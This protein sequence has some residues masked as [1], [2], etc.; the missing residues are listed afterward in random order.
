MGQAFRRA[1]GRIGSSGVDT[2]PSASSRLKKPI[3]QNPPAV[4][5][6]KV[7]R[8]D[9][10]SEDAARV[11]AENVLEERDSGYDAMLSQMVGRIQSKPGGKLEMGEASLVEKYKRPLPKLRNMT[12]DSSGYEERPAPLGTLNVAQIRQIILLHQGKADDHDGPMDIPQIAKRFNVDAVQV[13]RIIQ[14]TALPPEDSFKRK[15][16]Q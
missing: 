1:T 16:N 4:P 8:N 6:N 14:F 13:Q 2:P 5:V 12:P 3:F 9:V 11:N 15:D 10:D 7:P